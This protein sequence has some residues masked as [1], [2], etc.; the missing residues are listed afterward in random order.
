GKLCDICRLWLASQ[1][2][3]MTLTRLVATSNNAIQLISMAAGCRRLS[4]RRNWQKHTVVSKATQYTN[5]LI[6]PNLCQGSAAI[7]GA[8][9]KTTDTACAITS[10][11]STKRLWHR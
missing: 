5:T 9:A 2:W 4:C 7:P 1:E 10:N 11:R 3:A 8:N 6:S